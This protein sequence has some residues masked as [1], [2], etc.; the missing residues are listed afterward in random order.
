MNQP[1]LPGHTE[2]WRQPEDRQR[3]VNTLFDRA[4][5]HY[6][7]ACSLM[8]FGSGQSYRREALVRAG[9]REGLHVLDV[10][11]G[12]GLLTREI[13]AIIGP[14]GRV[15]GIDPAVNMIT[16]G[17]RR[18]NIPFVRGVGERLPFSDG[19]FDVVTMGFA[20]RHVGDLDQTFGEYFRVLKADGLVVLLEITKPV[21][22]GPL[23][24]AKLYFGAV[25]P[26]LTRIATG[27]ADAAR[28]MR[29]YWSTI[30]ACVP[31]ESVL[32][33]LRR[34]GFQLAQRAVIG[35]LFSEYTAVRSR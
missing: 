24:L 27:N 29:F 2:Y 4:A 14:T 20:L 1:P 32:A 12:T 6:D 13:A 28:L 8:S 15:T 18:L 25:V 31:P 21:A 35:G 7:R 30:E 23:A 10:G 11:A 9:V 16:A 5:E 33:S 19:R 34:S 17:R 26:W 22:A 3:V